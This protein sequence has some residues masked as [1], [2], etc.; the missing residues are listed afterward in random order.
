MR[1]LG[2]FRSTARPAVVRHYCVSHTA[3]AFDIQRFLDRQWLLPSPHAPVTTISIEEQTRATFKIL[4][5]DLTDPYIGG[6][7]RRKLDALWPELVARGTKDVVTCGGCQSHHCLA[8]ASLAAQHGMRAHVLFRGERPTLPTGNH[9]LTRMLAHSIV[10]V[11]RGEFRDRVS[12]LDSY[13][14]SLH[15]WED[16]A[17]V[18]VVAEGGSE[19]SALLGMVRLV[20]W[21]AESGAA[22]NA[23]Q[24]LNIVIDSGTGTSA[25]GVALGIALLGL[26]WK[27]S[28]IMLAGPLEMRLVYYRQQAKSLVSAFLAKEGIEGSAGAMV[29]ERAEQALLWVERSTPRQFGKI[30]PG[31]IAA[32]KRIASRYGVV[33]DP[34][35][36]LASWERAVDLAAGADENVLML[37]TG[38]SAMGLCGLAQRY[39]A[40]F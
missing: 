5:D 2:N 38:S 27:V 22:G 8:V 33:L 21:L 12:M 40:E 36:T 13:A 26:P 7:K 28:G 15:E 10:Y 30:M 14:A 25:A 11:T 32:C 34:I 31:E 19:P 3:E 24:P 39:P 20:A 35:W 29:A 37:M 17:R 4:R 9:L 1:T 23:N 16:A 6:N 18:S